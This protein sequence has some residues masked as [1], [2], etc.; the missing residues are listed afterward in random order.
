MNDEPTRE[1]NAGGESPA[2]RPDGAELGNGRIEVAEGKIP[3]FLWI[4]WLIVLIWL[5]I[6]WIPIFHY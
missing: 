1:V 5:I 3:S 6:S 2:E 4:I